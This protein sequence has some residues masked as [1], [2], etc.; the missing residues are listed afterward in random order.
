MRAAICVCHSVD[1]SNNLANYI[2]SFLSFTFYTSSRR[3]VVGIVTALQAEP[4]EVRVPVWAKGIVFTDVQTRSGTYLAPP[5]QCNGFRGFLIGA[6]RRGRDGNRLP[7]S[8]V[9]VKKSEWRYTSAT[10]ICLHV[11]TLPLWLIRVSL[12]SDPE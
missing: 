9:E 11:L 8:G 4:S 6:R 3:T 2:C 1:T 12:E 7:P 10:P 5:P